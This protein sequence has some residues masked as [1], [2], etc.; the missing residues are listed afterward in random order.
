MLT[1]SRAVVSQVGYI[2]GTREE[3]VRINLWLAR[4]HNSMGPGQVDLR[5]PFGQLQPGLGNVMVSFQIPC[6]VTLHCFWTPCA[7][8][9][10]TLVLG[11]NGESALPRDTVRSR[12]VARAQGPPVSCSPW[13][14]EVR[15]HATGR[16]KYKVRV[17]G[18]LKYPWRVPVQGRVRVRFMSKEATGAKPTAGQ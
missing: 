9:S 18:R 8:C 14:A 1:H 15:D 2:E 4:S 3:P 16:S 10:Q 17:R 6:R 5:N 12:D 7:W 13:R 11:T